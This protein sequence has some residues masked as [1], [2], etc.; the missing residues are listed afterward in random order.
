MIGPPVFAQLTLLPN[1][2]NTMHCNGPPDIPLKVP[3]LVG[4]SAPQLIHGYLGL[5]ESTIQTT[6]WSVQPFLH[7]SRQRVPM[8]LPVLRFRI[9]ALPIFG[10]ATITLGIGPHSSLHLL[11]SETDKQILFISF[12]QYFSAVLYFWFLQISS[13]CCQKC[14]E[15]VN[16]F[17]AMFSSLH[18]G[19]TYLLTYLV[20]Y[21]FTYLIT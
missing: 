9:E 12:R 7:R 19:F 1:P 16:R 3:L 2:R 17:V 13:F 6:S 5:L 21:L 10:W 18:V 4:A 15:W 8:E 20:T 14:L 11:M